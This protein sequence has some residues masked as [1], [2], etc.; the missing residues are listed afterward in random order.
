MLIL[1]QYFVFQWLKKTFIPYLAKWRESVIHR[2]GFTDAQRM[3]LLSNETR[4]T[5]FGL[6]I[7]G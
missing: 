4:L 5:R 2:E 6:E 7:T 3:M 1:I